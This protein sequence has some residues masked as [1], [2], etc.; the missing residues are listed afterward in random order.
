VLLRANTRKALGK[1]STDAAVEGIQIYGP[2]AFGLI[3]FA[4]PVILVGLVA[5]GA[6]GVSSGLSISGTVLAIGLKAAAPAVMS[7]LCG[8]KTRKDR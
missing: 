7:A 6:L 3:L 5:H 2:H 4:I 8:R 1:A